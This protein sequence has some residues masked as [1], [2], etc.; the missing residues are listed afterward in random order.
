MYLATKDCQESK[1]LVTFVETVISVTR[2]FAGRR[3]TLGRPAE[4]TKT[5][6]QSFPRVTGG[7]RVSSDNGGDG[8][9]QR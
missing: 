8:S 4:F 9:K 6:I 7:P 2:Q 1:C 5:P 3:T